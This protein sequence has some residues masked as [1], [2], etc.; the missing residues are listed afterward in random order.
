MK[1]ISYH[2]YQIF[3]NNTIIIY[4]TLIFRKKIHLKINHI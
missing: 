2:F 1:I 3:K 4:D